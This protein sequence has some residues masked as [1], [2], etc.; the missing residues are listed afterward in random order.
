M[1]AET[2]PPGAG[3]SAAEGQAWPRS[4]AVIGAAGLIGSGVVYQL[5][6]AGVGSTIQL[7]DLKENVARA[8]AIDISEAQVL[9]GVGAPQLSV[10]NPAA[11]D[12]FD[13]VDVVIVAASA[14]EVPGGDRRD[15]LAANLRLLRLLAPTIE[16]LSGEDGVVLLL[17]N[18]V[19]VLADCLHRITDISPDRILGYSINDS[20]RFQ[21]AVARELGIEPHR[22]RAQ[23]LG[24]HGNGQVPCFSSL[25]VDGAPVALSAAQQ[26]H[27]REDIDGWFQR[28]SALE[29]GRS[30][31]WTTPL[32]VVRMIG[33][34]ARGET[35]PAAAWTA[36]AQGLAEAFIALPV[37]M[38]SGRAKLTE[39]QGSAEEQA[40][41]VKAAASVREAAA[42]TQGYSQELSQEPGRPGRPTQ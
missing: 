31:G 16:K 32:G 26:E 3:Q 6:L 22:I 39:W 1:K 23:V 28:W 7:V 19:D 38:S 10:V 18:P 34:M 41:L 9:A 13:E 36:G 27:I 20:V 30:S 25:L 17:S 35:F 4:I 33:M 29:P 5:A 37:T 15:F 14:P 2:N 24:E 12:S 21:A 42:L 8:H 11:A 40:A